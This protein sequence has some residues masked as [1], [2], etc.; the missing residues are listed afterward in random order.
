LSAITDWLILWLNIGA[1]VGTVPTMHSFGV[2]FKIVFSGKT[3]EKTINK[4]T[5]KTGLTKVAFKGLKLIPALLELLKVWFT[6]IWLF[7]I[8]LYFL[9][10]K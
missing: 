4:L 1:A 7:H 2:A 3:I 5:M 8:F 9:L 6:F 10:Y